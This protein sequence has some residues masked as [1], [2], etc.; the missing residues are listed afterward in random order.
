MRHARFVGHHFQN[1]AA[2]RADL[3]HH[4]AHVGGRLGGVEVDFG[5]GERPGEHTGAD[6]RPIELKHTVEV[7]FIAA[8]AGRPATENE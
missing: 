8:K 5:S 2:A 4:A 1:L 6:G 7:F 3:L